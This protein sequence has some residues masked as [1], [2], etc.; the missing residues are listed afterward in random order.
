[1]QLVTRKNGGEASLQEVAETW[2]S[3][4]HNF[5]WS[6]YETDTWAVDLAKKLQ[7]ESKES[8]LKEAPAK[9]GP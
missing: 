9:P 2:K 5:D 3:A 4:D 8:Q 7:R 6:T 1:M